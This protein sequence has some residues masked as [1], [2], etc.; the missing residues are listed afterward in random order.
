MNIKTL[1]NHIL[2]SVTQELQST[3]IEVT[4][5]ELIVSIENEL[6]NI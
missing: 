6:K 4:K 1:I 5:E 3:E 2:R